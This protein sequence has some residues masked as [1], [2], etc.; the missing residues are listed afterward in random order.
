MLLLASSAAAQIPLLTQ[1]LIPAS[2]APGCAAFTVTVN[3][4]GFVSGAVVEWNNSPRT[5]T[6]HSSAQVSAAILA[7]DVAAAGTASVTVVNPGGKTSNGVF[8]PVTDLITPWLVSQVNYPVDN[9]EFFSPGV[10]TADFNHDDKLDVA[11]TNANYGTAGTITVLLGEGNGNFRPPVAYAVGVASLALVAG[12]FNGDGNLDLAAAND[13]DGTVSVLLGNGDGTFQAQVAYTVGAPAIGLVAADFN[14]DG[15]LD[16]AVTANNFS[17]LL[18]NGDGTFQSPVITP[19]TYIPFRMAVGDFNG[20]GKLDIAAT[21]GDPSH[22]NL[23]TVLLG[24]GDGTFQ[25]PLTD[26][27]PYFTP[28]D[29]QTAGHADWL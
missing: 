26:T 15:K 10:V 28:E 11:V 22:D 9:G 25:P 17:I 27:L 3:G 6:F 14:G 4:T 19:A 13:F 16:L 23:I 20:D 24:N 21:N 1:P 12:D 18:G 29:V 5:T 8:F 7:S 2:T